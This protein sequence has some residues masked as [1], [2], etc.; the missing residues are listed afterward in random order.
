M[1]GVASVSD[2][3][4]DT[5]SQGGSESDASRTDGKRVG[6]KKPTTFKP[7]SFAKFSVAKAP[8]ALATAKPS[9]KGTDN[10]NFVRVICL[11]TWRSPLVFDYTVG[12]SIA[13]LSSALGGQD[14][15]QPP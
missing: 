15:Q 14:D 6:S 3:G 8:G 7:V 11:L 9:D 5:A 12:R 13:E 1:N 10:L 2:A 4:E